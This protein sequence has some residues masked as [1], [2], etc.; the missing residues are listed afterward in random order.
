VSGK[1]I[2][3]P[4]AILLIAFFF[5]PWIM[6]SCQ[7][8]VLG[9]M[10]GYQLATGVPPENM[11]GVI[12]ADEMQAE[13]ILFAV[14]LTGIVA[15]ILI[16]IALWKSD[17]GQNAAWGQIVLAAAAGL[18][19]LMEGFQLRQN[20]DPMIE[21][22]TLPALWGSLIALLVLAA[23]A[24]LDLVLWQRTRA[25]AIAAPPVNS[26]KQSFTAQPDP[27]AVPFPHP[28]TAV[29]QQPYTPS[30]SQETI[31]D[32]VPSAS[33]GFSQETIVDDNFGESGQAT[34]I[35][36]E[37]LHFK[38]DISATLVIE[39]GNNQGK[40]FSLHG[41]STIGRVPDNGI[42]IDDVAMSS[43]HARIKE[44]NGRFII[45]DLNSTN[46]VYILRA[47]Q[48][49]WEKQEKCE[50]HDGDKIK[51]GRTTLLFTT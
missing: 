48:T 5:F 29:P 15:L 1:I 28:Q 24:I 20:S 39:E 17:F 11:A 49:Q 31:V 4:A 40:Q 33:A 34:V 45:H 12:S 42:V 3:G 47:E 25:P 2:S 21:V 18:I 8:T 14:P 38:P 27:R 23:G 43:Y 6:V 10:S 51:L 41:D 46:G 50:L 30:S 13:P 7:G 16:G 22:T 35:K 19:F 32:E 36:T 37:V 9:E 44:E 26:P